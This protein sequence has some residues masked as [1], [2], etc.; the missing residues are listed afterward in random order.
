MLANDIPGYSDM[1]ETIAEKITGKDITMMVL[2]KVMAREK[3]GRPA[4][5]IIVE[6]MTAA[7]DAQLAEM[8]KLRQAQSR[9]DPGTA[10]DPFIDAAERVALGLK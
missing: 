4:G 9:I 5:E 8:R 6:E 1:I 2:S 7:F 3:E 10:P